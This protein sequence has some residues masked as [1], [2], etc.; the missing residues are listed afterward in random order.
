MKRAIAIITAL[1]GGFVWTSTSYGNSV[2]VSD[3]Y[4]NIWKVEEVGWVGDWVREGSTHIFKANMTLK[5][6][7]VSY[8][9]DTKIENNK[10]TV[11]RV[12]SSD[13]NDCM[14]EGEITDDGMTIIGLGRCA[15]E[16]FITPFNWK[17]VIVGRSQ[18]LPKGLRFEHIK[19]PKDFVAVVQRVIPGGNRLVANPKFGKI[20][21]D[22]VVG[23]YDKHGEKK[24]DGKVQ[25]SYSDVVYIVV[26]DECIKNISIGLIVAKTESPDTVSSIY[27]SGDII[28]T[29]NGDVIKGNVLLDDIKFK[30]SLGENIITLK[31]NRIKKIESNSGKL[32]IYTIEGDI[33]SGK[34]AE[35]NMLSVKTRFDNNVVKIN[36]VDIKTITIGE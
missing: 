11:S 30:P 23:I 21:S 22:V 26:D 8:T 5:N 19:N 25:S 9:A 3:E 33:V 24:C 6:H 36:V 1:V 4:G 28:S 7:R 13:G 10:V 34:L 35:L 18:S 31:R 15:K 2:N 16:K 29:L 20:E 12:N 17:A 14:Y 32:K 27:C